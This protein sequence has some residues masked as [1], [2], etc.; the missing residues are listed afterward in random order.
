M[1][2]QHNHQEKNSE[3]LEEVSEQQQLM[4]TSVIPTQPTQDDNDV[5]GEDDMGKSLTQKLLDNNNNNVIGI[6]SV[7]DDC[8]DLTSVTSTLSSGKNVEGLIEED[9][10]QGLTKVPLFSTQ[11]TQNNNDAGG[12]DVEEKSN[13]FLSA[14][15]AVATVVQE[16]FLTPCL[17]VRNKVFSE[18]NY[19]LVA[20][21][22]DNIPSNTIQTPVDDDKGA[23]SDDH[24]KS[25]DIS[26]DNDSDD[27]MVNESRDTIDNKG[28]EGLGDNL[29]CGTWDKL[30]DLVI[31]S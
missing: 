16:V 19:I 29:V 9:D 13:Q 24:N 3:H 15:S 30:P 8:I 2:Y 6:H 20:T 23:N 26:S 21:H 1:S 10:L 25:I 7:G 18:S 28:N 22:P 14:D 31:I 17:P 4:M 12:E 27:D 5:G 11:L